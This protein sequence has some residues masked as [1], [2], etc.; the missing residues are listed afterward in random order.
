MLVDPLDPLD[1]A[2]IDVGLANRVARGMSWDGIGK[3]LHRHVI[4]LECVIEKEGDPPNEYRCV[5]LPSEKLYS[6]TRS[7]TAAPA[8]AAFQTS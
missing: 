2:P 5:M 7:V 3:E 6:W 4:V 8:T 1:P